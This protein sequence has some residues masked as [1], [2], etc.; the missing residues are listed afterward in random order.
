MSTGHACI[1]EYVEPE[2]FRRLSFDSVIPRAH[3][4][5]GFFLDFCVSGH[6]ATELQR[7]E[8]EQG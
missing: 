4:R 3:T 2:T 8:A 6:V 5:D 7:V 1:V